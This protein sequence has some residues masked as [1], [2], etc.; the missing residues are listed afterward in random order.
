M[1][2]V[3]IAEDDAVTLKI[4]SQTVA[5]LGHDVEHTR[6][7]A[8]AIAL[9]EKHSY[10]LLITDLMMP[11]TTGFDVLEW[12]KNAH[13]RVPVLVCSSYARQAALRSLMPGHPL[14]VVTKPFKP[15]AIAEAV[16]SL[17]NE[18]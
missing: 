16:R 18:G 9:L 13:A 5:S 10:D 12:I 1:A 7:G 15:E 3:L 4:L 8:A 17:L 2:K 6:D 11:Q 14:V